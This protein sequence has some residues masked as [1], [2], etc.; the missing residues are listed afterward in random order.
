MSP[1]AQVV[2]MTTLKSSAPVLHC[3]ILRHAVL[4]CAVLCCAVLCCAVLVISVTA[5]LGIK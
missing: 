5:F 2:L 1:A 3:A 4:C